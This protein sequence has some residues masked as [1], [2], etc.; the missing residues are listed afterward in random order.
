MAIEP[1]RL[2]ILLKPQSV[3]KR[4]SSLHNLYRLL[5]V[6]ISNFV[7]LFA[8]TDYAITMTG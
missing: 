8:S 4:Q 1:V 2:A 5:L 7:F 6:A 3:C